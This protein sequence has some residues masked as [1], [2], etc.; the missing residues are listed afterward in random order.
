MVVGFGT[1]TLRIAQS[2]SLKEK[3]AVVKRVIGRLQHQ[4]NASVAEVDPND[5]HQW[6]RI[7]FA[8][9]GNDVRLINSKMDKM[10]NM[11]DDMMLAEI[12]DQDMEIFHQ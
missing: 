11:I 3:R 7:G 12:V 4:F 9:V 6:A 2:R 5:R 8:L 10:L 1:I